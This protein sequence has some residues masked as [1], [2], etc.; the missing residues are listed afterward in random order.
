MRV[1]EPVT[2]REVEMT[3]EQVL[4]SR[5]DAGGRITFVNTDFIEVSGFT[6]AELIGQPHNIVRHPSMPK[7]AFADLW[8]SLKAGRPWDGLVKNRTKE[9]DFYWVRATV[10]PI[11]EN[12]AT[13]GFIS[14]RV[15]PTRA[16]IAAAEPIYAAL[17][18]GRPAGVALSDG[19]LYPTGPRHRL[20][21]ARASLTGRIALAFTVMLLAMAGLGVEALSGLADSRDALR[22]VFEDRTVPAGQLAEIADGM[23]MNMQRAIL[24]AADVQGGAADAVAP[25]LREMRATT[26]AIDRT[27]AAYMATYL[28][29]EEKVLAADFTAKRARYVQEGLARAKALAERSAAAELAALVRGPLPGLFAA[30]RDANTAL[31]ALQMRVAGEEYA[32]AADGYRRYQWLVLGGIGLSAAAAVGLGFWLLATLRR[33]LDTLAAQFDGIA[34]SDLTQ[35]IPPPAMRELGRVTSLLRAVR[36]R[37]AFTARERAELDRQANLDRRAAVRDMADKVEQDSNAAMARVTEQTSAMAEEARGLADTATRVSGNA[38]SVAAAAAEALANAQAVGAASEQLTASIREISQQV[39]Q[40]SAV[41]QRAVAGGTLAQERIRSLSEA[42]ER[43]G[44]VVELIGNI[45]GQTNLLALNATIEAARAGDAGKGFAVVASEVKSLAGQTARSTG[46]ITR[47]IGEIQATTGAVVAAVAE[48]GAHIQEIAQVSVAVAA[49]VEQQASATQE[50]TRNVLQTSSAAQLVAERIAE[51]STDAGVAGERAAEMRGGTGA[52]A[53]SMDSLRTS[54]VRV[55]RTATA[56]ADRR[57]QPRHKVDMPCTAAMPGAAAQQTRVR[58]LSRSG[59]RLD[60]LAHGGPGQRGALTMTTLGADCRV[61]FEVVASDA[62][63]GTR[64]R[65]TQ[66]ELP[67]GLEQ[68]VTRLDAGKQAA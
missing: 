32:R 55:V 68:C 67:A 44:D 4:V 13:V 50:I 5:T 30:A 25:S 21:V 1:N 66:A 33:P 23:H 65:F 8:R 6:E 59:A 38:S 54:I 34:R 18:A 52:I 46:E 58:D 14:V 47:Q 41:A 63:G 12:G 57:L 43:I 62:D 9:G 29:P 56:D 24:L 42:A 19:A 28:T 7:E 22:T 15:R 48:I 16:E 45:A 61:E 17:R 49:A 35:P 64:V 10:T 60:P 36:A 20:R 40:A 39:S 51:V 37:I 27:W 2:D 3:D 31:I 11:V 26:E 53:E